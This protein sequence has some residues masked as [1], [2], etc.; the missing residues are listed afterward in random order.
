MLS[1]NCKP[2]KKENCLRLNK[3]KLVMLTIVKLQ[4]FKF[5]TFQ[6]VLELKDSPLRATGKNFLLINLIC[7]II[8]ILSYGLLYEI[9]KYLKLCPFDNVVKLFE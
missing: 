1:D 3:H 9:V 7:T 2:G 5:I 8:G 4:N 6:D